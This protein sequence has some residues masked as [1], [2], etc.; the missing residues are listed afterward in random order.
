MVAMADGSVRLLRESIDRRVFEALSTV[1]G[2]ETLPAVWD[3]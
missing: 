1:A 3:R 2:G